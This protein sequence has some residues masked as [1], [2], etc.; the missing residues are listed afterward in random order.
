MST[1]T[2]ELGDTFEVSAGIRATG[3]RTV[4]VGDYWLSPDQAR[5]VARDL[6]AA[7]DAL[8]GL[9]VIEGSRR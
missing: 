9:V 1:Y 2:D 4:F 7:A 3:E 5:S 6:L 8:T